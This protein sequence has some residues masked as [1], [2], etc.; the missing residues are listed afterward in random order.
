MTLVVCDMPMSLD[1]F[2]T[3]PNDSRENLSPIPRRFAP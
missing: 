2:V 3:L 1:G